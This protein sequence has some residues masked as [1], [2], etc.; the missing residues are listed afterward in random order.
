MAGQAAGALKGV[1]GA[2]LVAYFLAPSVLVSLLF[3]CPLRCFSQAMAPLPPSTAA[4]INAIERK[5]FTGRVTSEL[6]RRQLGGS[7]PRCTAVSSQIDGW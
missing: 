5:R 1:S 7:Q 6:D 3:W 4:A 2:A